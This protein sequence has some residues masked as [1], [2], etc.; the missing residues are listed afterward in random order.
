MGQEIRTNRV[1]LQSS[2]PSHLLLLQQTTH[3]VWG[4]GASAACPPQ[5]SG[6]GLVDRQ[7]W[8]LD[9]QID[10]QGLYLAHL[11]LLLLLLQSE[12]GP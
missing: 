11:L 10:V 4:G 2:A 6:R 5:L 1:H 3:I 8:P 9:V 7:G 12:K